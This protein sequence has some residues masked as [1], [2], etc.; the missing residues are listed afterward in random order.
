MSFEIEERDLYL[1]RRIGTGYDYCLGDRSE[2]VK[3]S[4]ICNVRI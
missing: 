2:G 1:K 3:L 4:L